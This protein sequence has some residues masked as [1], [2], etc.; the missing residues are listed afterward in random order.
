MLLI[1]TFEIY[2]MDKVPNYAT[3]YEIVNL[4]K[5]LTKGKLTS[6]VNGVLRNIERNK[7]SCDLNESKIIKNKYCY[8]KI[9]NDK[10]IQVLDE[11]K[12]KNKFCKKMELNT[13]DNRLRYRPHNN[14]L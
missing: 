12:E 1:G 3:I 11:I 4:T 6:F 14:R 13:Y 2:Y 10:E 7:E 9:C 8:F 5:V